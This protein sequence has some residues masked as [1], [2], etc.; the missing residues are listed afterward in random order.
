MTQN[1]DDPHLGPILEFVE[2]RQFGTQVKHD[3]LDKGTRSR[4]HRAF[5]VVRSIELVQIVFSV[6]ESYFAIEF[7]CEYSL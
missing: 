2:L 7:I 6:V 5:Q 1:S 3:L 4:W